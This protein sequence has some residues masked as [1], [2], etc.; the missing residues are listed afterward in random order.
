MK[1]KFLFI[2][3][4]A[5]LLCGCTFD[6]II[7]KIT[8]KTTENSNQTGT[9]SSTDQSSTTDDNQ[10]HVDPPQGDVRVTSVTLA[11][12]ST[13]I[14]EMRSETLSYTVLPINATNK[15]V[16]WSTSNSLVATVQNGKVEALNPGPKNPQTPISA[17]SRSR[18]P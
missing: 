8:G 16:T 7:S 3:L 15:N 17:S 14:E 13:S 6:D 9:D 2:P 11:K 5:T 10:S 18:S 12:E 1:K 4:L